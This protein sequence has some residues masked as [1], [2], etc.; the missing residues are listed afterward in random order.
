MK[1]GGSNITTTHAEDISLSGLFLLEVTKSVDREFGVRNSTT[2][3]TTDAR[4]DIARLARNL[5]NITK[6]SPLFS[7]DPAITGLNKMFN[8]KWIQSTMNRMELPEPT[9]E[10]D[11]A[12][13]STDIIYELTDTL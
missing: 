8:S 2:H 5:A 1:S 10:L 7:D 4:N 6:D 13:H 3:T 9:E 11:H 12:S